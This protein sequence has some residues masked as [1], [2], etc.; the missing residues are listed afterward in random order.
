MFDSLTDTLEGF[1][2]KIRGKPRLTEENIRE[3]L[4]E[5]RIALLEAD[6]HYRVVKKFIDTV[7]EQAVGEDVIQ[8]VN[9]A[10]QVVKIVH[11]ELENLMGPV[12]HEIPLGG[13]GP[14]VIM[15]AGLQGSG[16]T[17]TCGKLAR[18]L[19]E[20][21]DAR[22]MLCAAD[23][24]RPA[25]IDQLEVLGEDLDV[26][27]VSQRSADALTVSMKGLMEIKKRHCNPLI[28]DTGGRL[29]INEEMMGELRELK[30]RTGPDQIYLVADA[31][32]GQDAV[33]SAK[34]FN[35][36]LEFDAVILTN[37][38]GDARGG[39]ALSIKAVTGKS[40]KF[41]GV[42]ETMDKFEPF[43]PDRMADRILGMGDVVSLVEKAE[44]AIQEEDAR[45]L[46]E[47]LRNATFDLEDFRKQIKMIRNMGPLREI[48][49][50]M[51]F[52]GN[53]MDALDFD[54]KE[55][56]HVEAIIN[57][58]TPEERHR[59]ELINASRRHRIANGSGAKPADVNRL[60]KQFKK[61]RKLMKKVASGGDMGQIPD[62]LPDQLTGAG[63]P[64]PKGLMNKLKQSQ[65]GK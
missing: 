42:G 17:T 3:G 23:V 47:K 53:K 4:R 34:E 56:D 10:Q 43:Y 60:L 65:K 22:P 26:P 14:T 40:I 31:R 24:R 1:F 38:D 45:E 11:D 2:S 19:K 62:N 48:M 33:V 46:E 51:P 55:I 49:S 50:Y 59:P 25:A 41:V 37:L 20:Q 21:H 64:M 61:M 35:K 29:H 54:E 7:T 28:I 18:Y 63:G 13:D 8:G 36:Q 32:S 57:G 52:V 15:L 6:V 44:E 9:P 39:A 30:A 12:N 58:M 16:K 5:V 27:V